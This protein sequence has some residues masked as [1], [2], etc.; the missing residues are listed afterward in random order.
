MNLPPFTTMMTTMTG[1]VNDMTFVALVLL[2]PVLVAV[3]L[4]A[5]GLKFNKLG[6][7]LGD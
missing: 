6:R 1:K 2:V 3:D 5:V 4:V 7:Y